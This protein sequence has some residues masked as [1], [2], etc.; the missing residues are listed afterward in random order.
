MTVKIKKYGFLWLT[1]FVLVTACVIPAAVS[2]APTLAPGAVNTFIVQTAAAAATQTARALP[3]RSPTP[4][5][6]STRSTASPTPTVTQT[7]V[8]LLPGSTSSLSAPTLAGIS[9]GTS[10]SDYACSI[11]NTEPANNT[12][13][14]SRTDFIASWGVKNIGRRDWFRATMDYVYVSGDKLHEVSSYDLPKGVEIGRNVYLPVDMETFRD[15]GTYSTMW[16]LV[17]DN[18]YFC[19][20]TLTVIVQ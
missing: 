8:L 6:T 19:R 9:N 15:P 5:A 4:T 2:P 13:F 17:V 10:T 20:L 7:F 1:T 14:A 11:F 16:A 12:V 3:S 18:I